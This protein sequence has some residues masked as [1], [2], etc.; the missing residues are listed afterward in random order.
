MR[1]DGRATVL[2]FHVIDEDGAAKPG[3]WCWRGGCWFR[4]PKCQEIGAALSLRA[5]RRGLR[6]CGRSGEASGERSSGERWGGGGRWRE[7]R[8]EGGREGGVDNEGGVPNGTDPGECFKSAKCLTGA[9]SRT[10]TGVCAPR[11]RTHATSSPLYYLVKLLAPH[12]HEQTCSSCEAHWDPSILVHVC[13]INSIPDVCQ[14]PPHVHSPVLHL[15]C[16]I[17]TLPASPPGR[18]RVL[19]VATSCSCMDRVVVQ[20]VTAGAFFTRHLRLTGL[21]ITP[22]ALG[23]GRLTPLRGGAELYD[24]SVGLK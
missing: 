22:V 10:K 23:Q 4:L 24:S 1:L 9:V 17:S 14:P 3:L 5:G 16:L 6:L 21:K 20:N 15:L 18:N 13:S 8:R 7:G 19:L 12:L 2:Y 11:R